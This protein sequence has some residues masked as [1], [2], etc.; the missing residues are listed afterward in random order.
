MGVKCYMK[1]PKA[2]TLPVKEPLTKEPLATVQPMEALLEEMPMLKTQ[3]PATPLCE[4]TLFR[5]LPCTDHC[6][7]Y[8][9]DIVFVQDCT[10]SQQ[11]Y[12]KAS[13]DSIINI[14]TKIASSANIASD[15]LRLR[16]IGFR[17]AKDE[18]VTKPFPFTTDVSVMRKN[19]STLVAAGG[20]DGPEAVAEA[21][22]EALKSEWRVDATK[23]VIL[24][25]DAA[26]HGISEPKDKD[27][28]NQ[29]PPSR[30]YL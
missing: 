21:L 20:G 7:D 3:T 18:Y 10:A 23:L 29:D 14:S 25:T 17:D 30:G 1:E 26:P 15:A 27:Y 9:S 24:I 13:I 6:F 2:T 12:I 22:D 16:L 19:L 28:D 8:C 5:I 11:S 4:H